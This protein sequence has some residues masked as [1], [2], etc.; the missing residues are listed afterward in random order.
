M[1]KKVSVELIDDYDGESR[2]AGTV[3]FAVDGRPYEIDLS[4]EHADQL[5]TDF[6]RWA[7]H[8]R[9][10]SGRRTAGGPRQRYAQVPREQWAAIREW[11]RRNGHTVA[12]RGR[13]PQK[14]V[15]AFNS[16]GVAAE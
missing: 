15:D 8:A 5:R 16:A 12:N 3:E 11:A 13:I 7:R 2:A 10:I 6:A 1:V 14:I 4:E 9:R